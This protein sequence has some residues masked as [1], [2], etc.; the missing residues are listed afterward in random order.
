[1]N[2][3]LASPTG[4]GA[5][6]E[7]SIPGKDHGVSFLHVKSE[8]TVEKSLRKIIEDMGLVLPHKEEILLQSFKGSPHEPEDVGLIVP[9]L[10][11]LDM[12]TDEDYPIS[13]YG[14]SLLIS[15][16]PTR[17]SR[18]AI[19]TFNPTKKEFLLFS[20]HGDGRRTSFRYDL[21][22]FYLASEIVE[23][24]RFAVYRQ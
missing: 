16:R 23:K 3:A 15:A 7:S 19:G 12:V 21:R 18:G 9:R 17:L 10:V 6:A 1:M 5:L 8:V 22:H 24:A 2:K 11:T 20:R 14:L 13:A 4:S